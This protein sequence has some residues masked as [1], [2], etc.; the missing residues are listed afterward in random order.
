[1]GL[2][3][4]EEAEQI[5]TEEVKSDYPKINLK[6]ITKETADYTYSINEPEIDSKEIN[7]SIHKWLNNQKQEFLNNV[8]KNKD[9]LSEKTTP[10]LNIQM[11]THR[12]TED[13]YSLV[14]RVN[15]MSVGAND[16]HKVK[17]FNIDTKNDSL[18]SLSDI[19]NSNNEN[20]KQIVKFAWKELGKDED[21]RDKMDK[22]LFIKVMKNKENWEWSINRKSFTL[23]WDEREIAERSAGSIQID[24]PIKKMYPYLTK[25]VNSY[26][27]MSKEQKSEKEKIVQ[28]DKDKKERKKRKQERKVMTEKQ[29]KK[30]SKLDPNGKYVA[31]TF[32]DGPSPDVTPRV[33]QTLKD[34]NAKATFFMLGNHVDYYSELTSQIA[35]AGHE[36]GNHSRSHPDFSKISPKQMKDEIDYT[37]KQIKEVTGQSSIYMRPPYGAY[38][39]NFLDYAKENNYSVI[40]WSVDSQDWKSKDP[41]SINTIVQ[42]NVKPGS[43]VLLHDIHPTT[44]DA[45]PT[46]MTSL[47]SKGYEFVTVSELLALREENNVGPHY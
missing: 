32:D 11:S 9:L 19:V 39:D 43:I 46:L 1:M 21:I 6:T 17:V 41:K 34:H 33:L 28:Q 47:E 27:K 29:D 44:A 22:Y 40:L 18:L 35:E 16:E 45:L 2:G 3:D 10:Q 42:N 4:D 8:V 36:I 37:D 5:T 25:D 31:L 13:F 12:I 24:I 23:L 20:L 26:L 30:Q 14:F 7:D 38:N 15:K